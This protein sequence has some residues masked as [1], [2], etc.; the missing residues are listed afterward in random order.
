MNAMPARLEADLSG[1]DGARAA[2]VGCYEVA[3]MQ[4]AGDQVVA[5][6]EHVA[7]SSAATPSWT[8]RCRP[9]PQAPRPASTST[10]P[11]P[12]TTSPATCLSATV[13]A[14]MCGDDS[15]EG[16]GLQREAHGLLERRLAHEDEI[17]GEWAFVGRS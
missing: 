14:V 4:E 16:D 13:D 1:C 6:A 15:H 3:W 10:T 7:A 5:F 12:A 9:K 2:A 11:A 17:M 8:P